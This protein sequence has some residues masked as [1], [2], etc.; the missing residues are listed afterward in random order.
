[1]DILFSIVHSLVSSLIQCVQ[2]KFERFICLLVYCDT[3]IEPKASPML[4]MFATTELCPQTF[5]LLFKD[6]ISSSSRLTVN[7]V[8]GPGRLCTLIL[9][10]QPSE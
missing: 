4:D 5:L 7:S 3:G 1:M 2:H 9:L 6:P 10:V 8:C